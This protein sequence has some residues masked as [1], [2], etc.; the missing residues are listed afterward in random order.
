MLEIYIKKENSDLFKI[1]KIPKFELLEKTLAMMKRVKTN[2]FDDYFSFELNGNNWNKIK[3]QVVQDSLYYID[4]CYN[5]REGIPYWCQII[6][7]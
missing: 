3:I 6:H 5:D 2:Y 1:P 7:E 4:N